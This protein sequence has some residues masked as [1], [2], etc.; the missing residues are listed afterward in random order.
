MN[1]PICLSPAQIQF[2]DVPDLQ[3]YTQNKDTYYLCTNTNCHHLFADQN[4]SK[5]QLIAFYSEYTT[6]QTPK[7]SLASKVIGFYQAACDLIF[8][9]GIVT[10]EKVDL[11]TMQLI[12]AKPG[13]VLD[14]GCGSGVF[15]QTLENSGW[16]E[17]TGFDFDSNALECAKKNS[18]AQF[19]NKLEDISDKFDYIT[20]NH[21]VE[22][23][24]IND[25][26]STLQFVRSH[27]SHENTQ[28]IVRTP[29]SASL[30]SSL[31]KNL[32]RGLESPRH[33][34]IFN[35]KS[36][37]LFINGENFKIKELKTT[38]SMTFS[39]FI[40]SNSF[41]GLSKAC[42]KVVGLILYPLIC[43]LSLLNSIFNLSWGEECTTI[44]YR[45][46]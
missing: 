8:S 25:L 12:S 29:N 33:R 30:V 32:W 15:L 10:K 26:K 46:N 39:V 43:F 20:L 28:F 35:S 40:E 44:F 5:E 4:I 37:N 36:L 27:L 9:L 45:K 31:T 3:K 7:P 42:I 14:I 1:C 16:T 21:V 17:L 41:T 11:K 6:H 19:F 22:H 24:N 23:L 13:K 34:N 38:F 18:H 2:K